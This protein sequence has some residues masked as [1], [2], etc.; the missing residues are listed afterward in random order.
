[1]S[2]VT[3]ASAVTHEE[4]DQ[5]HKNPLAWCN[6]KLLHLVSPFLKLLPFFNIDDH[7]CTGFLVQ[8]SMLVQRLRRITLRAG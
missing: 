1:M 2:V 7:Q 6:K 3:A 8:A 4:Q 5:S